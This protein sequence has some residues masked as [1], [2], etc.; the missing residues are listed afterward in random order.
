MKTSK[1]QLPLLLLLGILLVMVGFFYRQP[2]L[3]PNQTFMGGGFDGLKNYYTP[4]Y[5]AKY[6]STYTHFQGMNYP[7]GDHVVFADAQPLLSNAIKLFGLGDWTVAI[8][9]YALILSIFLTGWLLFRILQR[10]QV[11]D[12]WAAISAAAVT[13]LSPQLVKMNGHYALAYTFVVPLIWHLSLRFFE[14]P[15][16]GRSFAVAAP[17]FLIGWMHPYFVM[18]SAVFLTAFWASF[19]LVSWRSSKLPFKLLHFGLQ[20]IVP[21]ALF[22]L[23][24]K[25]TDPVTDRPANPYGINEYVATWSTIFMPVALPLLKGFIPEF[26]LKRVHPSWEG[27]S[28]I[29]LLSGLMFFVFWIRTGANLIRSIIQRRFQSFQLV[30]GEG[31]SDP[32]RKLIAAS[33]LAG[34]AVGIF[35][36]GFPFAIKPERMTELFPPIKQF[37]SLGRFTWAFY[38]TWVTFSFYLV[39]QLILWLR[40]RQ[41]GAIGL[42][43][44][45]VLAGWTLF[46]GGALNE[47]VRLRIWVVKLMTYMEGEPGMI[48][49]MKVSPWMATIQ[50]EK[51]AAIVALPYY[52]DGSENFR[53]N[54]PNASK[55]AFEASIRTGLPMLNV[56]MSRTSLNQTWSLL[57]LVTEANAPLEILDKLKDPRP[58]LAMRFGNSKEFDGPYM[59]PR[60]ELVYAQDTIQFYTLDLRALQE[61]LLGEKTMVPDSLWEAPNGLRLS[62][63]DNGMFWIDYEAKGKGAG[64]RSNKGNTVQLKDNNIFH[65]GPLNF[66]PKDTILVSLWLK[67]RADRLPLTQMGFEELK[68]SEAQTWDYLSL[69]NN[70]QRLDGEWALCEREF[71]LTDPAV[72]NIRMNVTTWKR[73]PPEITFDNVLVRKK[74]TDVYKFENGIP[75]WKNNRYMPL[76]VATPPLDSLQ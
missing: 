56:M 59:Q 52:H 62:R 68:G 29:G 24:L 61:R 23:S 41:M 18:I 37:R 26:V 9:N 74:G 49:G 67:M 14:K 72:N 45:V 63:P 7:Y 47:G 8:V 30:P 54:L 13:L 22:T 73:R 42:A 19:S 64:Y 75:V 12:Y 38:Y 50:P 10:W 76:Q 65:E 27:L 15:G 36:C 71:V 44:G 40:K 32:T 46:E 69:H 70:I 58:I 31:I 17:V 21:V 4:W 25:M 11:N 2:L 48:P 34:L 51:Y 60:G 16:V 3:E 66:S 33:V 39:W 35:A 55:Y 1:N 5:H 53:A 6:D 57:Q 20:V 43:I 28:Y